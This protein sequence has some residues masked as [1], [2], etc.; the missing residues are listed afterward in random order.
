[1]NRTTL[2]QVGAC[3][4]I[5]A[6]MGPVGSASAAAPCDAPVS[7]RAFHQQVAAGDS[8]YADMDLEAFQAARVAARA[9]VPCL[10]EPVTPA[11]AAGY[12]RLEALG[13]FLSRDHAGA[14]A[15]LR[16]LVAAAPGYQ[17]SSSIAPDGHPL[18]LYFEIAENTAAVPGVP[19]PESRLGEVK[20]DGTT[21][22]SWP[23]DR[24]YLFQVVEKDGAVQQSSLQNIGVA[25]P[26][27]AP[28]TASGPS[29]RN[30]NAKVLGIVS[31]ST[32]VVAGGL[33]LGARS[34]SA[35][36][37]D[38]STSTSELD[39]LRS[40]TNTL[41]WA[42]AGLGVVAVGTGGAALLVGTW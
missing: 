9:M 35:K 8:A 38:P 18:R 5:L 15:S 23:L 36:F 14:V 16:S 6:S 39:G 41:G 37:W 25:P 21:A 31:A 12:H 19:L 1:V 42:S 30:P 32:A 24:P 27:M 40:R 22:G 33:Y 3:L 4:G 28:G 20:I 17:L 29:S 34:A 10:A 7:A 13:E 11:Q 26:G 2:V